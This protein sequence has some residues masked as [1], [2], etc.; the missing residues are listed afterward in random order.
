MHENISLDDWVIGRKE[1]SFML[2]VKGNSMKDAGILD[3]DMV[4]VERTENPKVGQIVVADVD[5]SHTM[6]YLRKDRAGR[7]YL[8]AA[9]PDFDDIYPEQDMNISAVVKAVVRKY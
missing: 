1:A 8:E 7:F 6:K 2:K 5:G 3:G 9:N 4:I